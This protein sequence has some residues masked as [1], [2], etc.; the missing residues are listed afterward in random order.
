M[1][2]CRCYID[3]NA[4]NN[5]FP[6]VNKSRGIATF[7]LTGQVS[8]NRLDPGMEDRRKG[9][10]RTQSGRVAPVRSARVLTYDEHGIEKA[11]NFRVLDP[12]YIGTCAYRRRNTLLPAAGA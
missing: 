1:I 11:G 2:A 8:G 12:L 7:S 5:Y 9:L 6:P 10:N 3:D 4:N